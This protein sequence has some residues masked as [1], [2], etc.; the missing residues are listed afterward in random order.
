[1][2]HLSGSRA[3]ERGFTLIELLVVI[4]ILA[5]LAAILFPVF[6]RAR[7]NARKTSCQSNLRQISNAFALY[8]QDYDQAYPNTGDPTLFMGRKWRWPLQP[9]LAFAGQ[10]TGS[11]TSQ[12]FNPA[13]LM[14]PS[15]S[16]AQQY[17]DGT[18]YS[19]SAAFYTPVAATTVDKYFWLS[20]VSV[21]SQTEA[22]VL[23]PAQKILAGEWSSN[24]Q[25]L[26]GADQGWWD[27]GGA[28]VFLFAD[29]HVRF[30]QAS[31]I[32]PARDNLPDPNLT[33]NGVAGQDCE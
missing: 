8:L 18:S 15:D 26:S 5:I 23:Y 17:Y 25:A 28:R 3:R 1:M 24:H 16:I 4:A 21:Q 22:A 13:V 12:S 9:Y 30:V 33:V 6:A 2:N 7:E 20:G 10:R 27:N 29:G 32:R 19:Y 14:C 31:R 11:Y